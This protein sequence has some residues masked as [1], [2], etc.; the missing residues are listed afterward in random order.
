MAGA[1][2]G[3]MLATR[4]HQ[5][6]ASGCVVDGAVR[7]LEGMAQSLLPVHARGVVP[8]AAHAS[9]IPFP[10]TRPARFA[11]VTVMPDDWVLA[12]RDGVLFL[13]R[14][15]IDILLSHHEASVAKDEFSRQLLLMGFPLTKV[16]PLPASLSRF[17]DAFRAGGEMPEQEH[18]SRSLLMDTER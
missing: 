2:L 14:V 8:M 10:C 17:L 4:A 5:L 15:L 9:L 1:V 18:V 3:D 16:F 11:G 13:T 12:D 7:D 6:G